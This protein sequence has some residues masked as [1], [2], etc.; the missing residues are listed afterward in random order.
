MVNIL[1][2]IF[3]SFFLELKLLY[4]VPNGQTDNKSALVQVMTWHQTGT[5]TNDNQDIWLHMAPLG[6][7]ELTE[8]FNKNVKGIMALNSP[9]L[10]AIANDEVIWHFTMLNNTIPQWYWQ[11]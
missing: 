8:S 9:F 3:K 10:S 11:K 2:K 4:F 7:N 1:Q 5:W 6:Y